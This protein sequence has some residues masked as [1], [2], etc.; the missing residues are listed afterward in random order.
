LPDG[1]IEYAGRIDDQV[2]IRGY[3][4]ELGEI[5]S[6]LEQ[7][8]LVKQAVVLAKEDGQGIK[9]L[10][11][12]LVADGEPDKRAIHDYLQKRLPEY[13]IPALWV[14]Q[15]QMPV[16]SNGKIDRKALPDPEIGESLQQ[17][18]VAPR[19]EIEQALADIWQELMGIERIGVY[20]N[21]F[22]RGGHSLLA[23][24]VI[25]A[26]RKKLTVSIPV[27][28]LF[29]FTCIS[30]LSKYIELEMPKNNDLKERNTEIFKIIDV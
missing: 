12:Y 7:S 27:H 1:N 5:E 24:R 21:F 15:Q 14:T 25:S 19:N 28:M 4:I 9:R 26:I 6:T 8:G 3:R 17:E 2:K 22:E 11:G 20:D 30:D 10:V 29:R 16:T 23:M 18:Y 13:M